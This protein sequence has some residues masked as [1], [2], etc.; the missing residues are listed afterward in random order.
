MKLSIIIPNYN[1]KN[2]IKICIDSLYNQTIEFYEIIIVDNASKDGSCD[3]IEKKYPNIKLIK[4]ENNYGFSRAVNEGIK[5]SK[6]DYIVLLNNDT[7]VKEDWLESLL[8]CIGKDEKIFSCCSK[9]IRYDE[10]NKIDDAGDSYTV[11]GWA[12]KYG[13]G[14]SIDK[15]SKDRVVFSSCAG[16]AIYRKKIFDEI[17]YLDENF[18]AYLE[19]VDISYRANIYGYKNVYCSAAKVY[20]I[21][22]GTS[23][24]RHNSFKV[25]LA[26]RN[27]IYLIYKNM[28]I[29][30]LIV[31]IL[32]LFTGWF[33]KLIFF[34]KKGYGK[35][36]ILGTVEAIKTLNKVKKI[37]FEWKNILN[38]IKIEFKL[39]KNIFTLLE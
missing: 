37:K 16:A 4:L 5:V 33:I 31:N 38:Y 3:Y 20:H 12:H 1:G 23:G 27:N 17:G 26:A 18:F 10:K 19:D 39:I 2:Y 22:S 25:R 32:F 28:S 24:G 14:A 7:E 30:Q 29:I 21:G 13:D 11:L 9:M 6:G 15:Y 35:D 8:N 34:I 36:Y